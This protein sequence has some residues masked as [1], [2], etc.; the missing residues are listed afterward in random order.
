MS[1]ERRTANTPTSPVSSTV[2]LVGMPHVVPKV[3]RH[4]PHC[5][6]L[7]RIEVAFCG[8]TGH[9][10]LA[11]VCEREAD[12]S[13]ADGSGSEHLNSQKEGVVRCY[14]SVPQAVAYSGL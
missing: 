8:R 3:P 13:E 7:E 9:R 14:R 6:G 10:T 12:A 2:T 11:D 1:R 4:L 5:P